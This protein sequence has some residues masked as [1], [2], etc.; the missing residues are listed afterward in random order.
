LFVRVLRWSCLTLPY[1]SIRLLHLPQ[2][3]AVEEIGP[4][5]RC[6][7]IAPLHHTRRRHIGGGTGKWAREY[8]H[9]Y[10]A[11]MNRERMGAGCAGR[12]G[13]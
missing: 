12:P 6:Q 3:Y 8:T 11:E 13:W 10:K 4:A 2:Q 7:F 9:L 5:V 1:Y